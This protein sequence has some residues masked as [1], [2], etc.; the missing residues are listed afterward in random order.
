MRDDADPRLEKMVA[1]LYGELPV[2]EEQAFRRLLAQ[3][4]ALRAD[5]AELSEARGALAGWHVEEHVP[6]FV[7]ADVRGEGKARGAA[8]SAGWG[9]RLL[10]S[11][12]S[13]GATPAWALATAAVA[14]VVLAAAGF[15]V[16]RVPAGVAFRFGS[17]RPAPQMDAVPGLGEGEPLE[18]A[19]RPP[20]TAPGSAGPVPVGAAY[21][22]QDQFDSYNA[23]LM[24][25]LVGLLNRYD[26][27]RDAETAELL[28]ALYRKVNERQLFDYERVN[29]RIDALGTGLLLETSR[30]QSIEDLLQGAQ[31]APDSI[32]ARTA[33]EE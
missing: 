32:P 10:A 2:E 15:R 22:T 12:R 14:L 4:A 21:L 27:R 33:E 11:I 3:D 20:R 16:E 19:A 23:E 29:R 26:E 31:R 5:M 30:T 18:L 28:Q 13:F 25:T 9:A 1:F 24:T 6:G 8:P 17:E 7:L